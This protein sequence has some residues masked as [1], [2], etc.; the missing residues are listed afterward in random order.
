MTVTPSAAASANAWSIAVR[1]AA[2]HWSS[3]WPQLIDTTTG[4]RRGVHRLGD[5]VDEPLVGVVRE[6]HALGGA[7]RHR[8][9]DLDVELDLAVRG[10][11]RGS[12]TRRRRRR[13]SPRVT[14][15][16]RPEKYVF[17]SALACN[18]RRAR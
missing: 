3:D 16:P 15:R 1:P 10:L 14:E 12:W 2:D 13:R 4:V 17:R 8:A 18:R 7:R 11:R 6:V 5:R 9:D